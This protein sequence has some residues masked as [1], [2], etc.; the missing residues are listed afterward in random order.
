MRAFSC[1]AVSGLAAAVGGMTFAA[2]AAEDRN[3]AFVFIKP[4]ANTKAVQKLVQKTLGAK[5]ISIQKEGEITAA[6]IDKGMLIDT[7]YYAIASKATLLQPKDMNVPEGKFD[8]EFGAGSWKK[9]LADGVVYNALDACKVLGV[10]A[11]GL[12]ALWPSAKKVKLGGGFYCGLIAVPGKTPIYVMNGASWLRWLARQLPQAVALT[13]SLP[14]PPPPRLHNR[15]LLHGN[16]QQVCGARHVH[17][18][19]RGGL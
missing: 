17:S 1:R 3:Q 9:A 18:L 7:H 13:A 16:A 15:R 10:D 2:A 19:L 4:H 6:E 12:D 14:S 5:G 11:S 8:A